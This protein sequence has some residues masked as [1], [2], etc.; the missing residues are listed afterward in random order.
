M[1]SEL[2]K[3]TTFTVRLPR[4]A[5]KEAERPLA[6]A[7]VALLS[8]SVRDSIGHVLVIDD[9]PVIQD[10]MK[11]FLTR[12]GYTVTVA[13]SG[14]TGLLRAREIRPD[15]ITLDIAMPG[16]DGWSVLS[17]LKIVRPQRNPDR[18]SDDGG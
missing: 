4:R 3:G 18:D 8:S 17:A 7:S 12:E 5:A 13:E 10:L 15:V 1:E 14:Q 9:D 16:M 2:G 6:V 11:S